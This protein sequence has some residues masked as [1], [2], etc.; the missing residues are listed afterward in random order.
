MKQLRQC[1]FVQVGPNHA[2][3]AGIVGTAVAQDNLPG[4]IIKL[5]PFPGCILRDPLG[6]EDPSVFFLIGQLREDGTDFILFIPLRRFQ[7]DVAED[8]VRVMLPFAVMVVMV[9]FMTV[10]MIVMVLMLIVIIVI[11]MMVLMFML[12]VMAMMVMMFMFIFI[13]IVI[14]VIIFERG[15]IQGLAVFNHIEHEIGFHL[16]PGRGDNPG[17]GMPPCRR[18]SCGRPRRK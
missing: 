11:I 1:F 13:V 3:A 9:V 10:I 8:F 17:V 5:E 12:M 16:I 6:A 7:A 14:V 2:Q 15:K 4:N 18:R